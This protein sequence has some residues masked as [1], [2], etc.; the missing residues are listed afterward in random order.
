[1]GCETK[2][3]FLR[4]K[5]TTKGLE[6]YMQSEHLSSFFKNITHEQNS[7]SGA[8]MHGNWGNLIGRR[9]KENISDFPIALNNWGGPLLINSIG[10]NNL[11]NCSMLRAEGLDK[12]ITFTINGLLSDDIIEEWKIGVRESVNNICRQYLSP[13]DIELEITTREIIRGEV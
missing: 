2:I 1:M 7:S 6:V 11:A 12:G 10:G 4:A 9:M 5:R 3:L 8:D 13:K